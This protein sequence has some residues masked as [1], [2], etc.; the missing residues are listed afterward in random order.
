MAEVVVS[1][2]RNDDDKIQE[3]YVDDNMNIL[4]E[5]VKWLAFSNREIGQNHPYLREHRQPFVTIWYSTSSL[6][7]FWTDSNEHNT[8][9]NGSC[10]CKT[11]SCRTLG[12][13]TDDERTAARIAHLA[14]RDDRLAKSRDYNAKKKAERAANK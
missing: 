10:T 6:P 5:P 14:K 4:K 3:M 12:L 13:Y 1:V 8:E 2:Q 11:T 9:K 7:E